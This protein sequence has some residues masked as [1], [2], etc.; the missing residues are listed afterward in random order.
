MASKFTG[1]K[2]RNEYCSPESEALRE[3]VLKENSQAL[4]RSKFGENLSF[5]GKNGQMHHKGS[6]GRGSGM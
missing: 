4:P 2:E 5:V 3:T 6:R 1:Q